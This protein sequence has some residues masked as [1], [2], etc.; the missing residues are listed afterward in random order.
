MIED[1]KPIVLQREI[2][3]KDT[4]YIASYLTFLEWQFKLE[5]G[6]SSDS[7]NGEKEFDV[8]YLA[9]SDSEDSEDDEDLV[10]V[11]LIAVT[12]ENSELIERQKV[13]PF[14]EFT[15]VNGKKVTIINWDHPFWEPEDTKFTVSQAS[16]ELIKRMLKSK[17]QMIDSNIDQNL[18]KSESPPGQKFDPVKIQLEMEKEQ[19]REVVLDLADFYVGKVITKFDG[20][21]VVLIDAIVNVMTYQ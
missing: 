9:G 1:D 13:N 15:D 14:V 10:E 21:K 20:Q 5:A 17:P 6:E 18:Q 11:Q 2:D 16:E 7:E 8:V 3:K 4:D 12:D 19:K